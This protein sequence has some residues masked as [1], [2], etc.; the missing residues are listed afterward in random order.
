VIALLA[1]DGCVGTPFYHEEI[2]LWI[3]LL[4][5]SN[6]ILQ[7][8]NSFGLKDEEHWDDIIEWFANSIAELMKVFK[9]LLDGIMKSVG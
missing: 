2:P 9:P 8:T 7:L 4:Q 5:L 1:A 3:F 6:F